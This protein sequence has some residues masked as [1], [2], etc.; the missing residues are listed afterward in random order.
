M[1]CC[2]RSFP[3]TVGS[4]LES[5]GLLIVKQILFLMKMYCFL[6]SNIKKLGKLL[7]VKKNIL[8]IF[9][10]YFHSFVSSNYQEGLIQ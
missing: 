9:L 1:A 8:D 3:F 6:I 10:L 7:C 5:F 2:G 4:F